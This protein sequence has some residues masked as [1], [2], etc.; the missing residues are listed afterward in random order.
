[1][2][3]ITTSASS[4]AGRWRKLTARTPGSLGGRS[5]HR[6]AGQP[7]AAAADEQIEPGGERRAA[8][9]RHHLRYPS[10][11]NQGQGSA[12]GFSM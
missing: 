5:R 11:P 10:A 8:D 2:E 6:A 7:E 12:Q 4:R 9:Q 3:R 1:M